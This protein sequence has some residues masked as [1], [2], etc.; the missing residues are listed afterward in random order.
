MAVAL[1][2][3]VLGGCG[4]VDPVESGSADI[5]ERAIAT[6]QLGG[7]YDVTVEAA[8]DDPG[9]SLA[10]MRLELRAGD[11]FV[12][13]AR[14]RVGDPFDAYLTVRGPEGDSPA[15]RYGQAVLPMAAERDAALV[16]ASEA[17]R[18]VLVF[19]GDRELD[20]ATRFQLDLVPVHA[21]ALDLTL[22]TPAARAYAESLRR[23]EPRVLAFLATGALVEGSDG[24]LLAQPKNA[25]LAQRAELNGLLASVNATRRVLFEELARDQGVAPGEVGALLSELW[26]ALRSDTHALR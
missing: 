20:A 6:A 5:D 23:D 21:A 15:T 7:S 4:D 26:S 22:T 25:P 2:S 8:P 13:V 10:V 24:F 9:R 14:H 3:L 1:V 12:A 17:D 19:A 11:A 16:Y 18:S